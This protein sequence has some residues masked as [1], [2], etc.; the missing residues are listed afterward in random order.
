MF[1]LAAERGLLAEEAAARLFIAA[2]ANEIADDRGL[3]TNQHKLQIIKSAGLPLAKWRA[4]R[5]AKRLRFPWLG[6]AK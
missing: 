4:N 2:V 6:R 5:M 1:K 3:L